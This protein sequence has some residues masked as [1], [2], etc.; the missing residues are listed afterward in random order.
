M[1]DFNLANQSGAAFRAE[2]NNIITDLQTSSY[3]STAPTTTS[4]GQFWVDSSGPNP[5]L[6]IRNAAD[7]AWISLGDVA[8]AFQLTGT[9]AFTRTLLDDADAAAA[10]ATLG[11]GLGSMEFIESQDASTSSS[12]DF[13]GF[14]ASK[15]DAY[16]FEGANLIPGSSLVALQVRTSTDGGTSY[17]SGASD[18]AYGLQ[19]MDMVAATSPEYSN[20][21]AVNSIAITD[22]TGGGDDPQTGF[23]GVGFSLKLRA[24]HLARDTMMSWT[25]EYDTGTEYRT[26]VGA[27]VRLA[28]ED[29]D[30]IEFSYSSGNIASGS[31]TMYGLRKPS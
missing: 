22:G 14:D 2:L 31:I 17:D 4:P 7:D 29:V 1:S 20:Q 30:A 5:V 13:T 24:P 27:G 10:R 28:S 6:K 25:C 11:V 26:G 3:G 9:T 12:L 19:I 23:D 18:Y 8:T 15:Y 21:A 16:V